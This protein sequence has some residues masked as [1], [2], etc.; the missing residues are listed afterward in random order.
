[1]TPKNS[2]AVVVFSGG[3]DSTTCLAWAL[4]RY[5]QVA[6]ITVD[7]GQRHRIE[8]ECA[9]RLAHHAGIRHAIVTVPWGITP[10][11][12]THD[13][14]ITHTD[15][16]PNTLVEGRNIM[17][18]TVAAVWAKSWGITE[19]ITGVCETDY[20]GY[21]DCR[22]AFI[23]S[24]ETTLQLGLDYP[25]RIQTPLMA[26]SKADTVRMMASWG[27]LAW[28]R[29]THTCYEGV[30]PPCGQ[31]PACLLR[32]KGFHDAGIQDPLWEGPTVAPTVENSRH[33]TPPSK[34]PLYPPV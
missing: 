15:S 6:A 2:G 5:E 29:D 1:M 8:L 20:S 26:C 18:L 34:P 13:I 25:I 24:L 23:T 22:A 19:V 31:C 12:L 16:V 3:Q 10:N 21:P 28:Y 4:D 17:L 30:W 11:A 7:Y 27:R 32:S 14:P 9:T 33:N